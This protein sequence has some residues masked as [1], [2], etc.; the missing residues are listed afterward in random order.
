MTVTPGTLTVEPGHTANFTAAVTGTGYPPKD[1]T[2]SITGNTSAAT[3]I[4]S[5]GV[6][7]LGADEAGPTITVAATSV[8][9][10][11]KN[12]TAT[13]TVG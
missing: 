10:T 9:D 5:D 3:T 7:S 4:N 8:Y 2:W 6:L 11:G 13:V 12:G 1:V